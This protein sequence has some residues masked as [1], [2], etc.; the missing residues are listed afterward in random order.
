[1]R[2]SLYNAVSEEDTDKLV[3]YIREFISAESKPTT[4]A[5]QPPL[6]SEATAST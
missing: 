4:A 6:P 3:A 1:M 2:A 5:T